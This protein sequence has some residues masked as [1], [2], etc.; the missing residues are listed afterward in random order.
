MMKILKNTDRVKIDIGDVTISISPLSF[1]QKTEIQKY[2]IE[3]ASGKIE[4]GMKGAKLAIQYAVKSIDGVEDVD[5]NKYELEL[6]NDILTDECIEELLNSEINNELSLICINLLS[7]IPKE[8]ID[9]ATNKPLEG[10]SIKKQKP[11]KNKK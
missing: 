11:K 2:M 7:G 9:P 6:D 10:V 8:F 3:A 1:N 5:G 4:S